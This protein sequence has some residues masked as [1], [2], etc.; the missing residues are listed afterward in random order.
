MVDDET[1]GMEGHSIVELENASPHFAV[2]V[3]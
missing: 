3:F 2:N 1:N